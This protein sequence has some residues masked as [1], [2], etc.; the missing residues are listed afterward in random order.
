MKLE[1]INCYDPVGGLYGYEFRCPGCRH[2]HPSN[3]KGE[4]T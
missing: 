3:L 2:D 4:L 1:R